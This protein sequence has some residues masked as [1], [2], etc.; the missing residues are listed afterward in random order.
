MR[1][2]KRRAPMAT[3]NHR[4]PPPAT[5]THHHY[6]P[7]SKGYHSPAQP[8]QAQPRPAKPS[9]AQPS[10]EQPSTIQHIVLWASQ[11][12]SDNKDVLLCFGKHRMPWYNPSNYVKPDQ[13]EKTKVH[14][15]LSSAPC[16]EGMA[17]LWQI[18]STKSPC[19]IHPGGNRYM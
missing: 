9:T 5:T 15:W 18:T 1:H 7:P 13:N 6:P 3:T 2:E 17:I 12:S 14:G 10:P 8:S 16:V 4:Q 19:R 11:A